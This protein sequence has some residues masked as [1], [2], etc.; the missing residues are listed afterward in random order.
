MLTF[1]STACPGLRE[2]SEHA[3]GT[4]TIMRRKGMGRNGCLL[5]VRLCIGS[6][7][8]HLRVVRATYNSRAQPLNARAE[9][10]MT[11]HL[12]EFLEVTTSKAFLDN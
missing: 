6:N 2:E 9:A 8:I 4:D 7:S 5:L 11:Q 10:E 1:A 3:V 12:N